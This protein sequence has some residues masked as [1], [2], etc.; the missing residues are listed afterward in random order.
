MVT[1]IRPTNATQTT[2]AVTPTP[3]P[4]IFNFG[5]TIYSFKGAARAWQPGTKIFNTKIINIIIA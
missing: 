3:V 4:D 5:L 1:T 2:P